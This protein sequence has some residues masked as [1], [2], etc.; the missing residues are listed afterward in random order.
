MNE[1]RS[2]K[3]LVIETTMLDGQY[4]SYE[5]LTALVLQHFPTSKWQRSHYAWYKS[6][7]RTGAFPVPGVSMESSEE[8]DGVLDSDVEATLEASVS[9]ESDLHSYLALRIEEVERGLVLL[10]NGVE[11]QTEAGRI[12]LLAKDT[13]N[14]LVAVELKAGKAGDS[15]L[16]QLLGYLGCLSTTEPSVRGILIASAFDPRVVFAAQ[17]LPQVK[18][19]RYELAF[20][21]HSVESR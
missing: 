1:F 16:G 4:P 13:S 18:L 17:A 20:R 15:A 11:Y 19:I 21:L 12:D 6:K 9:L 10:P 7:I 14:C 3:D 5:K 8:V 2:I